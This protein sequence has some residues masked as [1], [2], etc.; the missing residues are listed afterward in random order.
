MIASDRTY[1]AQYN[2]VEIMQDVLL[3]QE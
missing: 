3:P 2:V 1:N